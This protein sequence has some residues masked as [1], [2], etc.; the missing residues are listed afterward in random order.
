[1]L[2][3][4]YDSKKITTDSLAQP[5]FL[6]RVGATIQ[7]LKKDSDIGELHDIVIALEKALSSQ[8]FEAEYPELYVNYHSILLQ[9]KYYCFSFISQKE[10]FELINKHL[11][12]AF[13]LGIDLLDISRQRFNIYY[14]DDS[15]QIE[16]F[17]ILKALIGNSEKLGSGYIERADKRGNEQPWIK[18]WIFDFMR[19]SPTNKSL[20]NVDEISYINQSQNVKKLKPQ[21]RDFL[22]KTL[23]FYDFLHFPGATMGVEPTEHRVEK[24]EPIGRVYPEKIV[25]LTEKPISRMPVTEKSEEPRVTAV[26]SAPVTTVSRLPE[27]PISSKQ[28]LIEAFQ[29]YESFHNEFLRVE[30]QIMTKTQGDIN[31]IKREL[32]N[33]ALG[34]DK[35]TLVACLKILARSG[36]LQTVLADHAAWFAAIAESMRKKYTTSYG[37]GVFEQTIGNAKLNPGNPALLSEFLQYLLKERLGMNEND[38]A[39]VGLEIGQ[40]LFGDNQRFADGNE[41]TGQFEWVKHKIENGQ[42]V[43]ELS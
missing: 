12:L 28:S 15:D 24:R 38:S 1:M 16:R 3:I 4:I 31:K 41:A 18:N 34:G 43:S 8:K 22:L 19:S 7:I 14:D 32:S 30:D 20:S 29:S 10:V 5:G 21:E 35:N 36:S 17:N 6:E 42:L 27:E 9:G 2:D 25:A 33:A 11:L 40:M 23:R 26:P 39:L 13:Q 37:Q